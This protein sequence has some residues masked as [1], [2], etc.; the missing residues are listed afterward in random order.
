TNY[1]S[2]L[3]RMQ[4]NQERASKFDY[5]NY[6][7]KKIEHSEVRIFSVSEIIENKIHKIITSI[8]QSNWKP[9]IITFNL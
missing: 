1:F 7:F 2:P 6:L 9:Q 3:E 5:I 8:N 4:I